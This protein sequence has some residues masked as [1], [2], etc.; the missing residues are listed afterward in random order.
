MLFA[1]LLLLQ[2]LLLCESP[3]RIQHCVTAQPCCGPHH[4]HG[5]PPSIHALTYPEHLVAAPPLLLKEGVKASRTPSP[6]Q[7][8]SSHSMHY[9][10]SHIH[11]LPKA[12]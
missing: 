12:C 7:P 8:S 4:R 6:A 1:L 2:M 9:Q 11:L 3:R 10:L 5:R